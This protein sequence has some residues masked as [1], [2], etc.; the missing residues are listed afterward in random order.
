M[1]AGLDVDRPRTHTRPRARVA[2]MAV[3][4]LLLGT[5]VGL[6]VRRSVPAMALTL[7]IYVF[8]QVAVPLWVRP[9]LVPQTSTSTVI[10]AW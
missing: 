4:A 8:V 5:L 3:F 7:A 1:T 10:S 2:A 9:H 6:V